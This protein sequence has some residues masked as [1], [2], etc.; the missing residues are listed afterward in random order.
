MRLRTQ[1][2]TPPPTQ[3]VTVEDKV[4]Q[5]AAAPGPEQAAFRLKQAAIE[6]VAAAAKRSKLGTMYCVLWR[7]QVQGTR[8]AHTVTAP[9]LHHAS[10]GLHWDALP[11]LHPASSPV[12]PSACT[13]V[14]PHAV[15]PA[16][17]LTPQ[18]CE[19]A[20]SRACDWRDLVFCDATTKRWLVVQ[21]SPIPGSSSEHQPAAM[22]QQ[23]AQ[24]GKQLFSL[25]RYIGYA[26]AWVRSC[27]FPS[28][29]VLPQGLLEEAP[30]P[31][32]RCIGCA[33]VCCCP[34]SSRGF[35]CL[36]CP[37]CCGRNAAN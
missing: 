5:E 17:S 36:V 15:P 18:I 19:G 32:E 29:T 4:R 27:A 6:A 23:A 11:A 37:A 16:C 9:A 10:G 8:C 12:P 35:G 30:L 24:H 21:T 3:A 13:R 25:L 7:W 34:A 31:P 14:Q 33:Q 20:A 22:A 26:P 28:A 1:L 2:K